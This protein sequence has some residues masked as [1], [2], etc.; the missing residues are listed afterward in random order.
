[1]SNLTKELLAELRRPF[2]PS[3]VSWKPGK[4]KNGRTRAMAYGDTRAY[5]NRLDELVGGDWEV[6]FEPWGNDRIIALVTICGVTRSSTSDITDDSEKWEIG[7]M[8][9]EAKAFKRACSMFGLGR[10]LYEL[11]AVWVD[12]DAKSSSITDAAMGKLAAS[13][14]NHYRRVTGQD[15]TAP[16]QGTQQDAQQGDSAPSGTNGSNGHR[17]GAQSRQTSQPQNGALFAAVGNLGLK[18]Y[19][20]EWG[21]V[22][23]RNVQRISK[24]STDNLAQLSPELL[25]KLHAGLMKLQEQKVSDNGT[26]GVLVSGQEA[27]GEHAS[28]PF[29]ERPAWRTPADAWQWAVGK[30][31]LESKEEAQ[32]V[33]KEM[34]MGVFGGNVNDLSAAFDAF[35]EQF[36]P[37]PA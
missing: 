19:G 2:H 1:M 5:Q 30:G 29:D 11:P 3:D 25:Q 31:H 12:Y 32:R 6:R 7:G 24:G 8:A 22:C 18:L 28:N 15:P 37:E 4:V 14:A 17:N 33:W 10:Y 21:A 35:F 16:T 26:D 36:A 23:K 27:L 34:V 9:A 13:L 20:K